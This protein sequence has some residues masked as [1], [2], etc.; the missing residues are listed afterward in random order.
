MIQCNQCLNSPRHT[1]VKSK[2]PEPTHSR[3]QSLYR[4][5]QLFLGRTR[6]VGTVFIRMGFVVVGCFILQAARP[7]RQNRMNVLVKNE[8]F[9]LVHLCL[10]P[11]SRISISK[12]RFFFGFD[13][14]ELRYKSVSHPSAIVGSLQ[15]PQ[16]TG[17]SELPLVNECLSVFFFS[18]SALQAP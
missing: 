8:C 9:N 17:D 13:C 2:V 15:L 10:C 14:F 5:G 7:S 6:L 1:V 4:E 11:V 12:L 3:L 18:L 16:R